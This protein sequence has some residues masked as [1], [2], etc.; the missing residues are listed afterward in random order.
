MLMGDLWVG[1]S[2]FQRDNIAEWSI[3]AEWMWYAHTFWGNGKDN[4]MR[5]FFCFLVF[6]LYSPKN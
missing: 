6:Q 2:P 1:V 3:Y 4:K 5:E